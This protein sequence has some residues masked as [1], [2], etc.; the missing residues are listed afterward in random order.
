M[1]FSTALPHSSRERAEVPIALA[2]AVG[3]TAGF[4]DDFMDGIKA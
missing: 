1:E 4:G 2:A 3:V